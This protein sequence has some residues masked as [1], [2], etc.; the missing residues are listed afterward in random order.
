MHNYPVHGVQKVNMQSNADCRMPNADT[1]SSGMNSS[2]R[3]IHQKESTL[4]I[5]SP[6]L[7]LFPI[8]TSAVAIAL[9]AD[10]RFV[11]H[12]LLTYNTMPL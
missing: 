6:A 1:R 5:F 8:G 4:L 2:T 10:Q 3:Q 7:H 9:H 12:C 11:Y